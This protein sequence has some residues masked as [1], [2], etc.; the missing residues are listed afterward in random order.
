D[1]TPDRVRALTQWIPGSVRPAAG[2]QWVGELCGRP[3]TR[4]PGGPLAVAGPGGRP[5]P[6]KL[7]SGN[8]GGSCMANRPVN[9]GSDAA[10]VPPPVRHAAARAAR[11]AQAAPGDHRATG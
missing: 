1:E 5:G 11:A 9:T 3:Q 6:G 10:A 7:P 2:W 8:P 4:A